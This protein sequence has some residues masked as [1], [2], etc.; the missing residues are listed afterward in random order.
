[1]QQNSYLHEQAVS[2]VAILAVITKQI[3]LQYYKTALP[4]NLLCKYYFK[5]IVEHC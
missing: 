1:M 2:M 5:C 3:Q 4:V